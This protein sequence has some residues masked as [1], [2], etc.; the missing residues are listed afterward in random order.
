M[1]ARSALIVV[2]WIGTGLMALA[3]AALM[4]SFL[5]G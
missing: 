4:W 2:G 3:V 5:A 1:K